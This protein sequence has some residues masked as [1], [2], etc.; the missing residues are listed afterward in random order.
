MRNRK[1]L[2]IGIDSFEK[3]IRHNFYY[4][5]KTEMIRQITFFIWTLSFHSRL[6]IF[7]YIIVYN[8]REVNTS[9]CCLQKIFLL[10]RQKSGYLNGICRGTLAYL[11]AAAPERNAAGAVE[12][13]A[14]SS[15]VN[16]IFAL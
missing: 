16:V 1:K 6:R 2:P 13:T 11:I 9:R 10:S 5:D 8:K 12:S 15:D 14:Y 7:I 4:V 3:I